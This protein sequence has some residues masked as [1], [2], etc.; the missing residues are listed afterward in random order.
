MPTKNRYAD[1]WKDFSLRIRSE[2]AGWR[3]EC[4][5]I[6]GRHEGRCERRQGD[7]TTSATYTVVL[8]VAHL[9]YDGGACRCKAETGVKCA[10]ADHVLAMCA[11]CHLLI[12]LPSHM[13]NARETRA[14]KKDEV[15]HLFLPQHSEAYP[16]TT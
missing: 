9:D 12:D 10:N 7:P 1:D 15:R 3:C 11:K 6:C 16:S 4:D 8:T 2:R 14:K 13:K 5:G